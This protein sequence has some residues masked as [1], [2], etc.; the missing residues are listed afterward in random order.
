MLKGDK[1]NQFL[2]QSLKVFFA[3]TFA[4]KCKVIC[5]RDSKCHVRHITLRL[6][7]DLERE[8]EV[9]YQ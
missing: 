7:L 5:E 4:K 9:I 3:T 2:K 8:K 6:L 1:E